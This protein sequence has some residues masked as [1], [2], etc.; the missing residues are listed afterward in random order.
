[1]PSTIYCSTKENIVGSGQHSDR[2]ADF[3]HY[4]YSRVDFAQTLIFTAMFIEICL[5][6]TPLCSISLY[7]MY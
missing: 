3:A 7:E 4:A 6:G 1:M 5:I 2:L